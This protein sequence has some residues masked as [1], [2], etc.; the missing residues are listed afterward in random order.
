MQEF[1]VLIKS[2]PMWVSVL[3]SILMLVSIAILLAKQGALGKKKVIV[4]LCA[5][6]GAI[7]SARIAFFTL[8]G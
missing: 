5:C 8:F 4:E 6:L 3:G 2:I 1:V 7:L